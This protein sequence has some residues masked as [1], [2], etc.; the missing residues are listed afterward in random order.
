M[1]RDMIAAQQK[2]DQGQMGQGPCGSWSDYLGGQGRGW[3]NVATRR[4]A[5]LSVVLCSRSAA[6]AGW[7][8][9]VAGRCFAGAQVVSTQAGMA[10]A[11]NAPGQADGTVRCR[12]SCNGG[13]LYRQNEVFRCEVPY[14]GPGG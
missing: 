4:S 14:R 12:W 6:C 10:K 1:F 5:A 7:S 8:N 3:Q 11:A 9:V 13:D 2:M